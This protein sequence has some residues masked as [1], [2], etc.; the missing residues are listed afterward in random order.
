MF[1]LKILILLCATILYI[2]EIAFLSINVILLVALELMVNKEFKFLKELNM[3]D[4]KIMKRKKKLPFVISADF[5][6]ILVPK[7]NEKQNL[8][9]S[10]MNKY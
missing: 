3:L 8:N 10:Y 1:L 4:S 2:M 6:S 7:N 9:R 5:E